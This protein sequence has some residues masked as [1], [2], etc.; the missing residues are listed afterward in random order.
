[1]SDSFVNDGAVRYEILRHVG[2]EHAVR[3]QQPDNGGP[4]SISR[5][6]A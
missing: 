5:Q 3:R 6:P 2:Y 1:M 4:F